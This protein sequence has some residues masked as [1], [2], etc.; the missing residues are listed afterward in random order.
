MDFI[1]AIVAIVA[2]VLAI[3]LRGRVAVLEQ[4]VALINQR[5]ATS[6]IAPPE[7][8][9]QAA[10]APPPLP[11]EMPAPP[12]P[13]ERCQEGRD[14]PVDPGSVRAA[15]L[16]AVTTA[17][18]AAR[19]GGRSARSFEER[20]GAS[21]VVWIA[22]LA[23]ALGGIFMV[24]YS[25][26][27]GLI[28]PGVRVFLGGLLATALIAARR[29]DAAVR[30][31]AAD[32]G[33]PDREYA[34]HAHRRR[35][36]GGV[37]HRLCGL[38]ALRFPRAGQC[39][40]AARHRGARDAWRRAAARAIARGARTTR[41]V[42]GAAARRDRTA[43]L[44]GA[45][46]LSR[47]RHRR[48]VR[49]RACAAVALARDL[50]GRVRHAVDVPRPRR[51]ARRCDH[52]ARLPCRRRLRARRSTARLRPVLRAGRRGW[53][54]RSGLVG[55]AGGLPVRRRRAGARARP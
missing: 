26:E 10:P 45:V 34:G 5:L 15:A 20:F 18:P 8:A 51:P 44:L 37:R 28:G 7:A 33:R 42:R 25:I 23:L 11:A 52:A 6:R 55:R 35:H 47:D 17:S 3:K 19:T 49:A 27:A 43:E 40:F 12:A 30:V 31:H 14:R 21:W 48:V 39:L 46:S 2:I 13:A 32:R 24:Q 41:R 22:G 36:H 4:H 50:G 16:S 38:R 53:P 1:A 9:P 54:H 29:M